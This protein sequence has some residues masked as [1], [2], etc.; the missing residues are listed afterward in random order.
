MDLSSETLDGLQVAGDSA[1]IPEGAF[2]VIAKKTSESL[3]D[4]SKKNNILGK[5]NC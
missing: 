1:F 4:K 2:P 5:E 3:L